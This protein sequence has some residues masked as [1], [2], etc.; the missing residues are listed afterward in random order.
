M[1]LTQDLLNKIKAQSRLQ[2]SRYFSALGKQ[3]WSKCSQDVFYWLDAT[4]HGNIP[5]VYTKDPKPMFECILCK[6]K[7]VLY[8]NKRYDHLLI[9]HKIEV[10]PDD[11]H[12]TEFFVEHSRIR[13]FT[14]MPY[15]DPIIR[16]WLKE[17]VMFIEKSRDMM[18]TWLFVTLFTWEVLFKQATQH[19][20]QSE[21]AGKTRELVERAFFIYRNQPKFLRSVHKA[22]FNIGASKSGYMCVKTLESEIL[23]FP[24][25]ADQIRQYHPTGVFSDE[26]A[27]Q[28][29]AGATFAAIKP[30]IQAGGRY[31]AVSS[32]N[33]SFFMY[34]V[35]DA[36]DI[37]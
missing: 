29:D 15:F 28:V 21:D 14:L 34:A 35:K 2:Q 8:F 23:G 25:G 27:Y 22:T 3:E 1:D 9:K 4:K 10:D 17:P 32:A 31:V 7:R 26:A 30:A 20:F 19:I 12:L 16:A 6:D 33:P 18:A 37:V 24:Q 5:Y 11:L 13:P 36:L